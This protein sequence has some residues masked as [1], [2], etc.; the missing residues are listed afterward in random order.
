MRK[1]L[2]IT[3]LVVLVGCKMPANVEYQ[4][5]S[6]IDIAKRECSKIHKEGTERWLQ[7]VELQAMSIRSRR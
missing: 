4:F 1:V 5:M 2:F 6:S 7:C 3:T